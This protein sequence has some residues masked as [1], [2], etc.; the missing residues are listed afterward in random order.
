MGRRLTPKIS[1]AT[2]PRV[3]PYGTLV[4]FQMNWPGLSGASVRE[5]QALGLPQDS[6]GAIRGRRIDFFMGAGREA[7]HVAGHLDSEG[8]VYILLPVKGAF[9]TNLD[10]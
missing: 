5:F 7:E 6:G 10:G 2:D 4:F 9:L 1:L 3:L 8:T